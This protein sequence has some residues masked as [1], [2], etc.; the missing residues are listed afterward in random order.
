LFLSVVV[1]VVVVVVDVCALRNTIGIRFVQ[2][3]DFH[4]RERER[5]RERESKK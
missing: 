1:V 2:T 5:E 3:R 4:E